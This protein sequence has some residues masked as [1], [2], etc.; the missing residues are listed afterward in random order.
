MAAPR[1][2]LVRPPPAPVARSPDRPLRLQKLRDRAEKERAALAHWMAR[3]KRAFHA[4]EKG[5]RA[6]A[7]L[8]RQL[9]RE[10][11]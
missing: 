7:R 1:R 6:L 8:E 2:R 3:L 11:G 10:G 5:Q 4:I 9:A